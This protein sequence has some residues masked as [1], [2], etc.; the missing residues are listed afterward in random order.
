VFL[1]Q[2]SISH[3]RN[4]PT[5]KLD[6]LARINLI[7]G[8]N[9]SGKTS[10]LESIYMLG[11]ARSFRTVK[12]KNVITHGSSKCLVVAKSDEGLVLGLERDNE[13]NVL[14]KH[15]GAIVK[16]TAQLADIL[17]IQ[18]I[19]E[20]SFA[21]LIEGPHV[22]RRFMDW[23]VFHVEHQFYKNWLNTQKA[24]K[25]RNALLKQYRTSIPAQM[26]EIWTEKFVESAIKIDEYRSLWFEMFNDEVAKVIE[27]LSP[28]LIDVTFKYYC[29][30]DKSKTLGEC[31][32]SGLETDQQRG[33]TTY[34]PQRADIRVKYNNQPAE[35]VLSRG[36]QKMI[37][38]AMKIAQSRVLKRI[39]KQSSYLVDDLAA[40]LDKDNAA[41]LISMLLGEV[42]QLFITAIDVNDL[43]D[44][45]TLY[46]D[47]I[48]MFH[49][50]HGS[51]NSRQ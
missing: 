50:E 24:L 7:T 40:E 18:L 31:L 17:P 35:E 14:I 23:G 46:E 3:L 33:F 37:V 44:I 42:K 11:M 38:A 26:L 13:N 39:G 19:N 43:P 8:M 15:D 34:G 27:S 47:R 5:A 1:K 32:L 10:I 51:V 41:K 36:Q 25:Q 2:L 29:G 4:I 9:G 12:S 21:L 16:S 30:W 28:H 20:E 22:R 6:N 48:A 45:K 49:V